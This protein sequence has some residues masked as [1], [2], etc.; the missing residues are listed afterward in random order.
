MLLSIN[1]VQL[2]TRAATPSRIFAAY[3]K[4]DTSSSWRVTRLLS[5]QRASFCER[6]V[7]ISGKHPNKRHSEN[8]RH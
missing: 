4:S 1:L 8:K 3:K 7:Y 6:L 5:F 2:I